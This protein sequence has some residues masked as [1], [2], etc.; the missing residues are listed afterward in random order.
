MNTV[1]LTD[2][3]FRLYGKA[4]SHLMALDTAEQ[5]YYGFVLLDL[6]AIYAEADLAPAVPLTITD[7][8]EI[9]AGAHE[10]LTAMSRLDLDPLAHL[11]CTGDLED[12]WAREQ[13][14]S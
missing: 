5:P 12:L 7:R 6:D 4:R 1:M 14:Q 3:Q 2:E 13:G 10:A 9:Y 11:L 8:A